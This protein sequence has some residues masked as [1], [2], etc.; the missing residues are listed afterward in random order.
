MA[1]Q[2]A[3][4]PVTNPMSALVAALAGSGGSSDNSDLARELQKF[5]VMNGLKEVGDTSP[6]Q[7]PWQAAARVSNGLVNALMMRKLISDDKAANAEYGKVLQNLP[8]LVGGNSA[9]SPAATHAPTSVPA[10]TPAQPPAMSDAGSAPINGGQQALIAKLMNPAPAADIPM[11]LTGGVPPQGIDRSSISSELAANPGL[12]NRLADMVKGEVGSGNPQLAQIQTESAMNRAQGRGIPLAQALLSVRDNPKAGYY[13]SDT[14]SRPANPQQLEQFKN[15]ILPKVLGGSDVGTKLLG[16]TPT[17]NASQMDFAGR[18]AAQGMYDASKWYSGIPGKGEMF[19]T[20]KGDTAR[21][22][23]NLKSNFPSEL[24]NPNLDAGNSP[25]P[26]QVAGDN[27]V[28]QPV[29]GPPLGQFTPGALPDVPNASVKPVGPGYV[30]P[31]MAQAQPMPS[32]PQS[33]GANSALRPAVSIPPEIANQIRGYLASPNQKIRDL[34]MQLYQQY[35]KPI[36][37]KFEKLNDDTLYEQNTGTTKPVGPGYRPLVDP[38]ERARFGIPPTDNRPY[39]V[40]PA[41][42]LVNPPPE[43]RINIDQRAPNEFEKEYGQGMGKRALGV[44]EAGDKAAN[45][46]QQI[47]LLKGLLSGVQTGKLTP[48]GATMGAWLQSFGI[49]P[50]KLGIDPKLPASAEAATSL[51]NRFAMSNIGA[52]SGGIPANN[53]SEA[54]RDFIM[55]LVPSLANRPEANQILIAAAERKAQVEMEHANAW[56]DAREKG[57]S[58]EKFE[59][60]WRKDLGGRNVFGDLAQQV[61]GIGQ[62]ASQGQSQPTPQPGTVRR[63]NPQT[64]K[65]E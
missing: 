28:P 42:K 21:L 29:Q 39:Q 40:G 63:F 24:L 5:M 54:D 32:T 35:A 33:Q 22:A 59:R 34:G 15:D 45:D 14:Y 19:V 12:V 49:D 18:R 8:G 41:N 44:V 52:A 37:P 6:V 48:T 65:I 53:F 55:R 3:P 11:G 36:T 58:Y 30:P 47:Q 16:F 27:V 46:Y 62:P 4:G 56:A 20:E 26:V 61:Q 25:G 9:P 38:A 23:K 2:Y 64:G 13:A 51:V 60:Q 57:T 43:N 10:P 31:Q 1:V 50:A 17:G 7:S